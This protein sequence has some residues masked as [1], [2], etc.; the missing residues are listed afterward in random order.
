MTYPSIAFQKVF[1]SCMCRVRLHLCCVLS[2]SIVMVFAEGD[3]TSITRI[4]TASIVTLQII[5]TSW[6][7]CNRTRSM[8]MNN[9]I[10]NL[11]PN[12]PPTWRNTKN[13]HTHIHTCIRTYITPSTYV[14]RVRIGRTPPNS[15]SSSTCVCYKP[16]TMRE[17]YKFFQ[18]KKNRHWK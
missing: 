12:H 6:L 11:I 15:S 9:P 7:L 4:G 3:T 8:S 17:S 10:I 5:D 14:W 1:I 2:W 16:S 18:P 13:T